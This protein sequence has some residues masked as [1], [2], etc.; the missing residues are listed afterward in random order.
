MNHMTFPT[1]P[2]A[3]I[4]TLGC[5]LNQADTAL[6]IDNLRRKGFTIRPWRRPA[7]LLVVNSCVVTSTAGQKTRQTLR[8]ARRRCPNAFIVLAG[9]SAVTDVDFW[10]REAAVDMVVPNGVKTALTDLLPHDLKRPDHPICV[11]A[12]SWPQSD[13]L[14]TE[15]G[16]GLPERRTRANL[17]VQEGC[18]FFCSYCIVPHARGRPRSRAWEDVLREAEA[19]VENGCREL[20]VTG[21]NITTYQDRGRRLPDLL[22]A[23]VEL[24]G[25]FRVRLS[26]TEPG[27]VL[28]EIIQ[29][30]ACHPD[31]ICR[32][33]HLAL[34]YGEDRILQAMN[35]R[36]SVEAYAQ[37]AQHAL[38]FLPDLCL[39]SDIIAGFPGET[40][41][42]FAVCLD[43][44]QRLPFAFLHVFTYSR[45][46]GTPAADFPDQVAGDV[47]AERARVL[48]DVGTTKSLN[49]ARRH[50]GKELR[51]LVEKNDRGHLEGWSGNYL[52]V[53]IDSEDP[54]IGINQ[55]VTT[56][57]QDVLAPRLLRGV[58]AG[59][60]TGG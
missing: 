21:V 2:T 38:K 24:P 51:V 13:A 23:L 52:R 55:F 16:T 9:C 34:Q 53:R 6:M 29:C 7:D 5:R 37:T 56:I 33:L 8:A 50:V 36:Y 35:R 12:G 28:P 32:S 39:S 46:P 42:S 19:L 44:V 41:A 60:E 22:E 40:Q 27:P 20:V 25:D 26:S 11:P 43:T 47:A 10:R 57:S 17:K 14:F 15:P 30:M 58:P 48:K 31:K 4:Y 1:P 18:D 3:S 45:R 54:S 59:L 49:F